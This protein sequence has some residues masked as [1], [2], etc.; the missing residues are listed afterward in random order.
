MDI[1]FYNT[2]LHIVILTGILFI[3][4]MCDKETLKIP[5]SLILIGLLVGFLYQPS[6]SNI[7]IKVFSI[8]FFFW[9]SMLEMIGYGDIKIIM[10]ISSFLGFSNSV[11]VMFLS[12]VFSIIYSIQIYKERA[13]F[14]LNK[15]AMNLIMK[16][17]YTDGS[18]IILPFAPFIFMGYATLI[19]I[20]EVVKIV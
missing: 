18:D 17:E 13:V 7:G 14:Y 19:I 4:G 9:F 20:G 3:A 8:I 6:I 12:A 2:E 11:I 1:F 10:V 5:N 15:Y 16:Q